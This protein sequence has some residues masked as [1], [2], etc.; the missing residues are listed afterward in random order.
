MA[1]K[2][3]SNEEPSVVGFSNIGRTTGILLLAAAA[4][5]VAYNLVGRLG[6]GISEDSAAVSFSAYQ[7]HPLPIFVTYAGGVIVGLLFIVTAALLYLRFDRTGY[8]WL[9]VAATC[10]ALAG[11]L[12]A[13]SASRWLVVL[14][15]LSQQYDSPSAS[16]ASRAAIEVDYQ[17]ISYYLGITLGEHLFAI[18][19]GAWTLIL[20]IH[21]LRLPGKRLWLG[22]LGVVA[23]CAWL[24]GS[25][26]PLDFGLAG[27]FLV[28][29]GGGPILWLVWTA[30]LTQ[31]LMRGRQGPVN[32]PV[33]G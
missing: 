5:T 28:F 12:L 1:E 24:L 14:P 8:P 26:E 27:F 4:G 11:L 25:L 23:G 19:T 22:W 21:L 31:N 20:A 6:L 10:Q 29:L 17:T 7:R 13:L 18:L 30:F 3:R 2:S 16:A 32:S 9:R 15:F 33:T